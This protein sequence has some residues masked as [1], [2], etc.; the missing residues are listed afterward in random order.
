MRRSKLPERIL[1]G[2]PNKR[3]HY[4]TLSVYKRLVLRAE[5]ERYAMGRG[6]KHLVLRN[7][8]PLWRVRYAMDGGKKIAILALRN[9]WTLP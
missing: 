2:R 1:T 6:G 7:T 8:L 3:M 5:K 9:L 4:C